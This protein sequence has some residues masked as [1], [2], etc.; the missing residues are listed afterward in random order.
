[1]Y[2]I[3]SVFIYRSNVDAN[4]FVLYTHKMQIKIQYYV[5]HK[6]LRMQTNTWNV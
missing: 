1:M 6:A 5:R 4:N 2:A 3:V